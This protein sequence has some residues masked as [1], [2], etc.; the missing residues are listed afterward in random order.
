MQVFFSF[1]VK[2]KH[3]PYLFKSIFFKEIFS[4]WSPLFIIVLYYQTMTP[5]NFLCRE[6]LNFIS[7]IQLLEILLIELIRTHLFKSIDHSFFLFLFLYLPYVW[8]EIN[9][10]KNNVNINQNFY[11]YFYLF[12]RKISRLYLYKIK[13]EKWSLI[14]LS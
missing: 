8:W 6:R 2:S 5:I 7:L 11:L 9:S 10:C 12:S 4:L 14:Q 13:N 1:S 3:T